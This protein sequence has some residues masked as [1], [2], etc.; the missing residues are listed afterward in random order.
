[1]FENKMIKKSASHA[2][3]KEELN[4][5]MRTNAITIDRNQESKNTSYQDQSELQQQD[6]DSFIYKEGIDNFY[7]LKNDSIYLDENS[8]SL[9]SATNQLSINKKYNVDKPSFRLLPKLSPSKLNIN[10]EELI[11]SNNIELC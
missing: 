10:E 1:M 11:V 9:S 6:G 4:A 8:F 3:S 2:K 5:Y 7:S